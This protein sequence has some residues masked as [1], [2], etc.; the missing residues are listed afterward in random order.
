MIRHSKVTITGA[1]QH[2]LAMTWLSPSLQHLSSC[3]STEA[4]HAPPPYAQ[5]I[6]VNLTSESPQ[7]LVVG[8]NLEF[9]YSVRWL[10][11]S[12]PFSKRFERYL[13]YN[14]FEHQVG[15][16]DS[17]PGAGSATHQ[18][19]VCRM[20]SSVGENRSI[21]NDGVHLTNSSSSFPTGIWYMTT[22]TIRFLGKEHECV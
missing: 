17:G 15:L 20:G 9:T 18:G 4:L 11:S 12:T 1:A 22:C 5:I 2:Y 8:G 16:W 14:F 6:Q 13:D 10:P 21:S 7:P 3:T 19:L